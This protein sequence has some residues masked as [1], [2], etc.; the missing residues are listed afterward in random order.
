MSQQ[1]TEPQQTLDSVWSQHKALLLQTGGG[2]EADLKQVRIFLKT[3]AQAG[4]SIDDAED[5]S[6]LNELIRYWSSFIDGKTGEFPVIQLQPF[7]RSLKRTMPARDQESFIGVLSSIR[8][9]SQQAPEQQPAIL[10]PS[11][12][13]AVWNVPYPRNPFFTGRDDL[14]SRL[15]TQL[16]LGQTPALSQQPQA[17]SGLGGIGKTQIAIEYAYRYYQ[18]YEAVLWASAESQE[19]LISSYNTIATLLRLPEREAPEQ[20]VV[21]QAAKRWLQTHRNW[22]LILDNADDLDLLPPLLPPVL[23]GHILITTRAWDMQRLAQ[24]I[25]VETL[26]PEQAALFLLRRT[27]LIAPDATLSQTGTEDRQTA[28]RI[29]QDLGGLPLA[30]DQA[31]AYLEATGMSLEEYQQVYQQH[32]QVLLQERRARVPDH[33]E[34]VATTWSLSFALV[35]KKSPAAVDLLRLCAFL[36]P[37]AIPEEILT[38]G[39][40]AL[41]PVLESVAGDPRLLGQAIEALRAYSL[42]GRDPIARTLSVHRLVQAV[43]QDKMDEESRKQWAE[44]TVRAVNIVFPDVEHQNWPQCDRLLPHAL[45]CA[46]LIEEHQLTFPEAARLLN[47]IGSYLLERAR[48]LEAEPLFIRALATRERLLGT[49]HPD[50]ARS[51]DSLAR[52]YYSQGKYSEAEP[53]LLR[54]LEIREQQLGAEHPDTARILNSLTDLYSSQ[55]KYSEA[56]PLLLRALEIRERLLGTEHPDTAESLDNLASL[57]YNQG[58]YSEAE[59]LFV[60]AL[61]IRERLLGAEHPDTAGSLDNL[62]LLYQEQGKYSEA[63]PLFVRALSIRERLLGTEHPDTAGSLDNLASLYYSQGKYSEAEPLLLRALQIRERLLGAEHPDTAGNLN[64]LA[65]L[66]QK[67]SKYSEAEPLFI[68][69]L[70]IRERQLG[71]EHPNTARSLNNLALLYQEQGKHSEAEPLFTR[72]LS[73]YEQNLGLEHPLTQL[74]RGNY[75]SLL[76]E[77]GRDEEAASLETSS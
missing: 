70:S 54:A 67:Q 37:D 46:E 39:A 26:P 51:L 40:S 50:T 69:A 35:E 71:K 19:A 32:R 72:A 14:L 8:D 4:A 47:Q 63:E 28:M 43:L 45:R 5:R 3:L 22:L 36:S 57:Y 34:P 64:N 59:S 68:R 13:P 1:P 11:Q 77:M 21:I 38:Q 23:G 65:L 62:A 44:R 6:S 74:I 9:L 55:G 30:L 76:R 53:L 29:A 7:D 48:Y 56:E 25:E 20:G 16:Q 61:Q 66:Y 10:L 18:E 60:R 42:I 17:I 75:A 33:P 73:I 52:L 31:G 12:L 58:K 49:E 24:R 15:H 2:E 41:G 27:S